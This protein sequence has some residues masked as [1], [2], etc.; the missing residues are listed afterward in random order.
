MFKWKV[1]R[2]IITLSF[3]YLKYLQELHT[4]RIKHFSTICDCTKSFVIFHLYK[5][6]VV[7]RLS[8]DHYFDRHWDSINAFHKV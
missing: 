6:K 8:S 1:Y 2:V 7:N 4:V 3:K 5:N